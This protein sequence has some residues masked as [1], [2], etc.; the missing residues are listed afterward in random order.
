VIAYPIN[1]TIAAGKPKDKVLANPPCTAVPLEA[2]VR[3]A[4]A[5]DIVAFC[6]NAPNPIR[7]SCAANNCF[8][9]NA[10][11]PSAV[12]SFVSDKIPSKVELL[13]L[14]FVLL[15]PVQFLIHLVQF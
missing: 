8:P 5:I 1:G 10:A 6:F 15:N 3:F 13:Q 14:V 4:S 2:A 9:I 7:N 12:S 11:F